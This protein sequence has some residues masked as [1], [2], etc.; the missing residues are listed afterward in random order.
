MFRKKGEEFR[1]VVA[2]V[3][4]VK[5]V[6]YSN[7]GVRVTSQFDLN[8]AFVFN[9]TGS[10]NGG[11]MQLISQGDG[12]PEDLPQLMQYWIKE[13]GC[14]PGFLSSVT[15]ECYDKRKGELELEHQ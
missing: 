15:L 11:K 9:P 14:I 10:P 8:A 2:S 4:G 3:L 13:Q 7:G 6:F 5:L 12:G 1:E